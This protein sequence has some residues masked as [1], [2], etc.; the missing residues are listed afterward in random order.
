MPQDIKQHLKRNAITVKELREELENFDDEA[1]V[2]FAYDYG[3]HTHSIVCEG[4]E[5]VDAE[6]VRWSDYHNQ[7]RIADD[8]DDESTEAIVL[9]AS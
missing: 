8:E 2:L 4:V 9:R 1:R 6:Q 3:D 5:S 7:P